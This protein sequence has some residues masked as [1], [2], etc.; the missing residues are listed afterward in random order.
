ML[1]VCQNEISE[2]LYVLLTTQNIVIYKSE[3][4]GKDG[5]HTLTQYS[6][7]DIKKYII[8]PLVKE[9]ISEEKD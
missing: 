5:R 2:V 1:G 9:L 6:K 4:E 7:E 3:K 8:E